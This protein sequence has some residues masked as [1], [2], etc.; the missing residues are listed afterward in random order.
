MLAVEVEPSGPYSICCDHR[1]NIKTDGSGMPVFRA[2]FA[3]HFGAAT[4]N[5]LISVIGGEGDGDC[6][7]RLSFFSVQP[8][9][10]RSKAS[11]FGALVEQVASIPA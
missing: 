5:A 2:P 11:H 6:P 9:L 8:Y 7:S 4:P 10:C 1:E 3:Q